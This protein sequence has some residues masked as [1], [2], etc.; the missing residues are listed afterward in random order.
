MKLTLPQALL[1]PVC[2]YSFLIA[3]IPIPKWVYFTQKHSN[4]LTCS[5]NDFVLARVSPV[6]IS[7][8]SCYGCF[9]CLSDF[10]EELW[11]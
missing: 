5:I 7:F 9:E 6:I 1:T 8:G 2:T 3:E 4:Q 10:M 11:C